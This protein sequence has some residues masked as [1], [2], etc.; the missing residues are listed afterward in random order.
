M[1]W[2]PVSF[3]I[4][5]DLLARMV[6]PSVSGSNKQHGSNAAEKINKTFMLHSHD[7][8]TAVK[9]PTRGPKVGPPKAQRI[10]NPEA[11]ENSKQSLKTQ[12]T[13]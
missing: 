7:A 6:V 11:T 12:I 2:R 3:L 4:L 8:K 9:L 5:A 10:N 13:D 1:F